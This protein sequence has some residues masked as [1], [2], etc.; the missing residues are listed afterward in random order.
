MNEVSSDLWLVGSIR[1]KDVPNLLSRGA[2]HCAE[3]F[4]KCN[5]ENEHFLLT[6]GKIEITL[7]CHIECAFHLVS[8]ACNNF[9]RFEMRPDYIN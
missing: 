4:E 8:S 9:Q 6:V 5:R 7:L 1:V 3:K 2:K